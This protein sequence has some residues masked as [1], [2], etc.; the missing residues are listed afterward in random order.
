MLVVLA[1]FLT[2][3][4]YAHQAS[5]ASNTSQATG[6]Q[7]V[8]VAFAGQLL[9]FD[10]PPMIVASRTMVPIGQIFHAFGADVT[11][12]DYNRTATGILYGGFHIVLTIGNPQA[13]VNGS[14][15]TL[16]AAPFIHNDR[17]MV[18][19]RFVSE[20]FG[21]MV[22]WDEANRRAVITPGQ[23]HQSSGV[24]VYTPREYAPARYN[25]FIPDTTLPLL[26][27]NEWSQSLRNHFH[28]GY[29]F[30]SQGFR[31]SENSYWEMIYR[32]DRILEDII[33]P[34][35]SSHDI[36]LT[37]HNWLA[38]NVAFNANAFNINYGGWNPHWRPI[39][40]N[41]EHQTAWAALVLGSSVCAGYADAFMYMLAPFE[42]SHGIETRFVTGLV[43]HQSGDVEYH[44]W[45]M[46]RLGGSWY[47]VD[48]TWNRRIDAD[49]NQ[50]VIHDWFLLSDN[51]VSARGG[52]SRNW[53]RSAFPVSASNFSQQNIV[54]TETSDYIQRAYNI[55]ATT[56]YN[57]RGVVHVYP[58]N[59]Q[60]GQLVDIWVD[61]EHNYQFCHW[62]VIRGVHG[63]AN[64]FSDWTTF[65]MPYNDVEIRAV[66]RAR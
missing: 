64:P 6:T 52:T 38:Y 58:H 11:W 45:N 3:A 49:G 15:H 55:N 4:T 47:H 17:T 44:A 12:D 31:I 9:Q 24:P 1:A 36:V 16:D 54:N 25:N 50:H 28:G 23:N 51:A 22:E 13:Y 14:H 34:Y 35:M 61:A 29:Y 41:Y 46:V 40:Y 42:S 21:A 53:N 57:H 60:P 48:I 10:T 26:D 7:A 37:V 56:D 65:T 20:S 32:R 19:L 43:L 5:N 66:F 30:N 39:R 27:T 62:L 8:S 63:V 59:A 18:P 33:T 2:V